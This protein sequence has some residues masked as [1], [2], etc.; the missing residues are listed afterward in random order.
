M[1][2]QRIF[3]EEKKKIIINFFLS[4][5]P[6]T[7]ILG[8][9]TI[10][11]NILLIIVFSTLFYFK[12]IIFRNVSFIDKITIALFIFIFLTGL[13]NQILVYTTENDFNDYHVIISKS[14]FLLRFLILIFIVKFLVEERLFNF[15]WFF[16]SSL[17]CVVFVCIDI[18]YQF[19]FLKDIFGIEPMH[20]RKLSGPFGDELI[21]GGYIQ[22]F[23]IFALFSLF[24]FL[25]IKRPYL[26]LSLTILFLLL[27]ISII[28]SG[29]RMPLILFIFLIFLVLVFEKGVR[30]Y[31]LPIF[32][33]TSIVFSSAY[34]F[35]NE[36][37]INFDKFVGST[38]GVVNI[39]FTDIGKKDKILKEADVPLYYQEFRSF[40]ETW[41]MNKLIGGG[42]KSFRENCKRREIK[43]DYERTECNTHPHNYYLEIMSE[44]G[45]IG[46]L[47]VTFIFFSVVYKSFKE[48]YQK[49]IYSNKVI[50]AILFVFI[51]E[52][53]PIRSS[54]SFFTTGNAT[55]I[56]LLYAILLGSI[57]KNIEIE[58]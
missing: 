40:Y 50:I 55:F 44:I 53:I 17:F 5:I 28:L 7:L 1:H 15:K 4:L 31:I 34:Y 19:Y 8:N 20:P 58:R 6:L 30:K 47:L 42:V 37:K 21:A 43:N 46:F 51:A 23:S 56:F 52:I 54:G 29:N 11:L 27:L 24:L 10:N 32:L 35:N 25:K 14:F 2:L 18:I 22:R 12:R 16:L 38:T 39:F 33:M 48:N 57:K 36:V 26:T 49:N 45:L 9:L 13:W 3:S 41:K